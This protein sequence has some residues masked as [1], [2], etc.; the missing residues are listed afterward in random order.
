MQCAWFNEERDAAFRS[1]NSTRY[2]LESY[3]LVETKKVMTGGVRDT[4]YGRITE[5]LRDT[6]CGSKTEGVRE[7]WCGS[8]TEGVRET[9][10]KA[11]TES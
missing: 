9:C 6:C 3:N 8:K 5:G 1:A 11:K 7:T 2:N 10:L 4:C